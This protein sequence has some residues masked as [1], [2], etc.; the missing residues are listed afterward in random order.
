[1]IA[2]ITDLPWQVQGLSPGTGNFWIVWVY[3]ALCMAT[4][5]TT[6]IVAAVRSCPENSGDL[7]IW[8]SPSAIF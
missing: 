4:P 1:M 2:S 6:K 8:D 7:L 5:E 3:P